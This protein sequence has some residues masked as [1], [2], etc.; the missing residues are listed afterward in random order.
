MWPDD[1]ESTRRPEPSRPSGSPS[2]MSSPD[3][4]GQSQTGWNGSGRG[5]VFRSSRFIPWKTGSSRAPSAL[6]KRVA[7]VPPISPSAPAD[8]RLRWRSSH[9]NRS[10]PVRRKSRVIRAQEVQNS[11]Q[12]RGS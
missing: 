5:G 2:T 1:S 6:E 3:C 4:T 9:E 12:Q 8:G 7:S 11:G 10:F